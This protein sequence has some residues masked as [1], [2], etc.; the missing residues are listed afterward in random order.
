VR[1]RVL[2]VCQ[3]RRGVTR[4]RSVAGAP[5]RRVPAR[6][7]ARPARMPAMLSPA[8]QARLHG[9]RPCRLSRQAHVPHALE[10]TRSVLADHSRCRVAGSRA[11]R[12]RPKRG[13]VL[14]AGAVTARGATWPTCRHCAAVRR[15]GQRPRIP[16]RS[17]WAA[18]RTPSRAH[19]D[20][21][22]HCH[23]MH[24]SWQFTRSFMKRRLASR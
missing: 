6:M 11:R 9:W 19:G 10:P 3:L 13:A 7:P 17:R 12:R 2:L 20:R 21:G 5:A 1:G 4:W 22:A 16:A 14:Q 24:M 15:R 23:K 8:C 18:P